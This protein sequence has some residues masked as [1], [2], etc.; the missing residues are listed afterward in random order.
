MKQGFFD[1]FTFWLRGWR[2]L[3]GHG[4]LIALAIVPFLIA[5]SAGGFATY[6]LFTNLS[7]WVTAFVTW[8]L[9]GSTGIWV[10]LVYYPLL[11]GT[12]LVFFI[13]SVFVGYVA[14]LILA[15][16]FY[17]LL[18]E[19]ALAILG[20]KPAA[21]FDFKAWVRNSLRMFRI[22]VV[23]GILFLVF[24][25]ILFILSFIPLVNILAVLGT[26][27]ILSFDLLDYSLESLS[28]G[29]RQR[30]R[31]ILERRKMW[32]GMAC[33]LGLTLFVPGLTFV[34]AP[35]AVVGGAL[36]LKEAH[37]SSSIT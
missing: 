22:S 14:H 21:P 20:M 23:K 4:S 28:Y 5:V 36:L 15:I 2:L 27:M 6:L 8:M 13:G 10:Q 9:G 7:A 17:A 18:A 29:L 34:V 32:V 24:G 19:R 31:F 35:G 16:P 3:L 33:G 37:G 11:V 26:L 12:G 1:G 30:F 25:V